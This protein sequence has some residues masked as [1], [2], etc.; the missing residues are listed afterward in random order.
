LSIFRCQPCT[1]AVIS[2]QDERAVTPLKRGE[3]LEM[4]S[5]YEHLDAL[6]NHSIYILREAYSKFNQLV[7]L[8]SIGK[9]S[10]VVL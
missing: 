5:R 4:K 9:D 8:W 10:S 7:M 3:Y 2:G 1:I 6:E